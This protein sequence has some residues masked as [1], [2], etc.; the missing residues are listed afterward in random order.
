VSLTEMIGTLEDALAVTAVRDRQP[1]QPGDVP[2]TWA[3][4]EKAQRLFGYVPATPFREGVARFVE[5]LK[6]TERAG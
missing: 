4:V 6:R 2:Q 3:D 5:W 1:E